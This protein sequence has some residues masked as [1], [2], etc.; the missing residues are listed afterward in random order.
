MF[1]KRSIYSAVAIT[2]VILVYLFFSQNNINS[3]EVDEKPAIKPINI[4]RL[5]DEEINRFSIKTQIIKEKDIKNK[6]IIPGEVGLNENTL[7]HVISPVNGVVRK[8]FSNLGDSVTPQTELA[9]IESRD[10]AEAKSTYIAAY[11]DTILKKDLAEREERLMKNKIKAETE[12]LKTR[13]AYET[14]KIDLDQKRQKLL[15]LNMTEDEIN[16]LPTTTK[17]LN[18]YS[19]KSPIK[20]KILERHISLGE[21]ITPEN[22]VFII[23]DTN[24][25]WINLSIPAQDLAILKKGQNVDIFP[26]SEST[27]TTSTIIFLSPV[28]NEATRTGRAIVELD[29]PNNDWHPGDFITAQVTTEES[30]NYITIPATAL[31]KINGQ[32]IAFIKNKD[33][34]TAQ[35]IIIHGSDKGDFI[36]VKSGLKIGDEIAV[37]NTF[38]LKAELGKETAEHGH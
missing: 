16:N 4:I 11:K 36:R 6:L 24:K 32:S 7:L 14:S 13:N 22:Q 18:I 15:A 20:G 30:A 21:F 26:S 17:P 25:V 2:L 31:Q 27:P 38:L 19:I 10:M 1:F 23:A 9:I 33:G 3:E 37:K 8:V 12:Y 29:N 35:N 34:F 28:I 5:N